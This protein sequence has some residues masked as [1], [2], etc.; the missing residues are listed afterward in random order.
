MKKL[1][2]KYAMPIMD[3]F[4]VVAVF[5]VLIAL[6]TLA[7]LLWLVWA[8]FLVLSILATTS[9]K[10]ALWSM[11]LTR[12][13]ASKVLRSIVTS[14]PSADSYQYLQEELT[15]NDEA[16]A[17]RYASEYEL[18]TE[19]G[20]AYSPV[21]GLSGDSNEKKDKEAKAGRKDTGLGRRVWSKGREIHTDC[22][23]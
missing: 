23:C 13:R 2:T 14:E 20:L 7:S 10:I 3:G 12:H 5:L 22:D 16:S 17:E 1:I 9:R 4:T 6:W 21:P 19:I 18:E 15:R 8:S 11:R